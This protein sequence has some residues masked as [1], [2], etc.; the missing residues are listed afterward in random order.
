MDSKARV[1]ERSTTEIVQ[2]LFGTVVGPCWAD[3]SCSYQRHHGRLYVSSKAVCFY[4]N[5]FGFERRLCLFLADLDQLELYRTTSIRISM[6]DGEDFVF[7]SLPYREDIFKILLELKQNQT[8]TWS[9]TTRPEYSSSDVT[10]CLGPVNIDRALQ[11]SQSSL[12]SPLR[13]RTLSAPDDLTSRIR[14]DLG[15]GHVQEL[16]VFNRSR[17]ASSGDASSV[18]SEH[19]QDRDEWLQFKQGIRPSS[20]E[21]VVNAFKLSCLLKSFMTHCW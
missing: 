18:G 2:N 5:L 10:S 16:D 19:G 9:G 12:L 7:K 8:P 14:K 4:S 1:P 15:S 3:C 13:R 17:I 21:M 20:K 11:R 6:V